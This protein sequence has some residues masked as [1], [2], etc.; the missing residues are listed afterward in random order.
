MKKRIAICEGDDFDVTYALMTRAGFKM[1]FPCFLC[2]FIDV[3]NNLDKPAS[4]AVQLKN[5]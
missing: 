1:S 2:V 5:S 4:L 3:K